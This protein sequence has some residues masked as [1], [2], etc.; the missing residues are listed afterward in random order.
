MRLDGS[1]LV[2][3]G[4]V[5]MDTVP[6]LS[7]EARKLCDE[8]IDS[9]DF[10]AVTTLDSAAIALALELTRRSTGRVE[11]RNLPPAARKLADLYSVSDQL[12]LDG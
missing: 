2:L 1:T 11:L 8:G 6:E 7:D 12:A 3:E 9:V 5:T 10:A 4:A